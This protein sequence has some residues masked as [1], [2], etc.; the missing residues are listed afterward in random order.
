MFIRLIREIC[1]D[2]EL[3]SLVGADTEAQPL[4]YEGAPITCQ[5]EIIFSI[6]VLLSW[7]PFGLL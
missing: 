3:A 5:G 7:R 1:N 4:L 2:L 6:S